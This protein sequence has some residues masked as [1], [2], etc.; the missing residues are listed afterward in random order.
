MR[1]NPVFLTILSVVLIFACQKDSYSG[2]VG[3]TITQKSETESTS[4]SYE[5]IFSK[6]G[7]MIARGIIREGDILLSAGNLPDGVIIE[8]YED[9]KVKNLIVTKHGRR[10]GPALG[11]YKSEKLKVEGVYKDDYPIGIGKIYYENG[12]LMADWE[13]VDGKEIWH[14]EYHENGQLKEEVLRKGNDVTR[15]EYDIHGQ[16]LR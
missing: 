8:K 11:F 15:K 10:N 12:N 2:S 1:K 13:I 9:G 16:V 7:E 3:V 4:P 5:V 14:K 6:N